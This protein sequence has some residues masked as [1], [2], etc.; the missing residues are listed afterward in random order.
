MIPLSNPNISEL[1]I[2]AV[3][4]VLRSPSLS[5]GPKIPEF[6]AKIS[7]YVGTKYAVAV[8]NGTCA[9]HLVLR[10]LGIGKGDEVITTPYTFIA[11][12]NSILFVEA[13]P[14]FVDINPNDYNIDVNL[15]EKK[16][17]KKTK[18]ILGVDVFGR[19]ADWEK[20]QKIAKK[21][22][23]KVIEDSC[24]A[25]GSAKA[26]TYGNAGVFGFYPNKQ[27]TCGEGGV[28]VTNDEKLARIARIERNQGRDYTTKSPHFQF[29][30]H[31]YNYRLSDISSVI[32]SKQMD[33]LNEMNRRR[34]EIAQM[35]FNLL[36]NSGLKPSQNEPGVSW[37]VYTVELPKKIP[38]NV[39]PKIIEDLKQEGVQA[40]NYFY[41]VHLQ[42]FYKKKL[43]CKRGMYPVAEYVGDRTIAL[44][45]SSVMKDSEVKTVSEAFLKVVKKNGV[46]I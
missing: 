1:E 37:F 36:A 38:A 31:G 2:Q 34:S 29:V 9:L 45:F 14:V 41:P 24:E 7:S 10:A 3:V 25:L 15:I 17:T 46:Q 30:Q 40:G 6:E 18:A 42:P 32:L 11:S 27:I 44:P 22:K 39:K 21:H 33:R 4:D 23:L 12:S 8:A 13:K 20:I 35:Y 5:L 19:M 28:I 43:G 16:I 26:G